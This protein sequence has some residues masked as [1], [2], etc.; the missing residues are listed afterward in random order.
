MNPAQRNRTLA[1]VRAGFEDGPALTVASTDGEIPQGRELSF[2]WLTGTVMTGLTSVML[3]GAA[4]YVSFQGQDT[5]ST[6]YEALQ[7]VTT[8]HESATDLISKTNRVLILHEANKTMGIGAE[9]S[10]FLAEEL[11]DSLDAPIVRVAA[12]DC[13]VPH[14]PALEEQIIPNVHAVVDGVRRLIEY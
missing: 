13:H 2:A 9:I 11:F 8:D 7:V 3:M 14:A 4:L 5:F 6:A 12:A 10:A 1:L